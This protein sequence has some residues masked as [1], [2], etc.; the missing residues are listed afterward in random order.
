MLKIRC[1]HGKDRRN[2]SL[3]KKK[4]WWRWVKFGYSRTRDMREKEEKYEIEK[5]T[6]IAGSQDRNSWKSILEV[7]I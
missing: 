5:A 1:R 3:D 2:V 4:T 7:K 6:G